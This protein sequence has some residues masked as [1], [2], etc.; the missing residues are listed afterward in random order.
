MDFIN[1]IKNSLSLP[2]PGE[3]AHREM[4]SAQRMKELNTFTHIVPPVNSAVLIMLYKKENE[5]YIPFI[6]RAIDNHVHSG[7]IALP[8]GKF[9]TC[10]KNLEETAMRETFEEIGIPIE[11]IIILGK[12]TPLYIPPSNYQ[13]YPFIG[14]CRNPNPNFKPDTKEVDLI[15]P[16]PVKLFSELET[17]QNREFNVL[18]L[19]FSTPCFE[20]NENKIWGATAMIINE[21]LALSKSKNSIRI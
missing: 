15:I 11:D 16:I 3:A 17:R 19:Q 12:L 8:G 13:V 6:K 14:Y 2:L 10:D 20:I 1:N 18:Q 5:W 7:Q 4:L 21:F 9:E